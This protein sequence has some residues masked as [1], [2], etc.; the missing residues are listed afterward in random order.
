MKA[1]VKVVVKTNV[2]DQKTKHRRCLVGNIF[3]L[4]ISASDADLV[5]N[6]RAV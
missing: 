3:W 2:T 6:T 4:P 5:A 1:E